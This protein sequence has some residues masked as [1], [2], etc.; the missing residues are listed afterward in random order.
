[1]VGTLVTTLPTAIRL[2]ATNGALA[3]G[4]VFRSVDALLYLRPS[5]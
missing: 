4:G 5:G 3:V 2:V 1:M